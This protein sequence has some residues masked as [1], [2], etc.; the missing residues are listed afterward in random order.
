MSVAEE[1]R[2][3]ATACALIAQRAS[4]RSDKALW[5]L[6]AEAWLALATDAAQHRN[7]NTLRGRKPDQAA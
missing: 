1:Y 2:D 7:L 4:D 6:M 5:L 3:Q